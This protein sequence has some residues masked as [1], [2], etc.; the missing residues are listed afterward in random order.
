MGGGAGNNENRKIAATEANVTQ[1]KKKETI[2]LDASLVFVP[3]PRMKFPVSQPA[4]VTFSI[5]KAK[6]T[7]QFERD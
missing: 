5:T 1:E 2:R 3:K 4:T 7:Q 6:E